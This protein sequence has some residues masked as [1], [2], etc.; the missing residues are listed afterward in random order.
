MFFITPIILH[1]IAFLSNLS[2]KK[3]HP[4]YLSVSL[5]GVSVILDVI[6]AVGVIAEVTLMVGGDVAVID[7]VAGGV[8][9][10]VVVGATVGVGGSTNIQ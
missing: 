5:L 2:I 1:H 4:Q 10:E 8:W 9:L 3:A 7:C 6:V